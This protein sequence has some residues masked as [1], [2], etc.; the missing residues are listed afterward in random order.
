MEKLP[1]QGNSVALMD[2][3]RNVKRFQGG[4][5]YEAHRLLYHSTLGWRVITKKKNRPFETTS[6]RPLRS[7]GRRTSTYSDEIDLTPDVISTFV[8]LPSRI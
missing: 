1:D 6:I 8:T 7:S 2:V 4:F 5:V 3:C